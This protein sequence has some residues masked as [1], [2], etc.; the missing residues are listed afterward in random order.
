MRSP[1]SQAS[2][3]SSLVDE[4]VAPPQAPEDCLSATATGRLLAA[5]G[6]V[7]VLLTVAVAVDFGPISRLD[8][9]VAQW[10]YDQTFEKDTL[11]SWWSGVSRWGAPWVLRLALIAAAAL[12]LWRRRMGI[13]VWLV[14]VA[15]V[16]N[17][18][19]PVAK[20][21]LSRPRPEWDNPI[22]VE[23]SLSYPSGQWPEGNE[24]A[25]F[26]SDRVARIRSWAAQTVLGH[27]RNDVLDRCHEHEPYGDA[28][29]ATPQ[30]QSGRSNER[31][32]E[33]PRRAPPGDPA[34]L[35]GQR[36][37]LEGPVVAPLCDSVVES[38]DR[39]EVDGHRD[40]QQDEH[41]AEPREQ[42]TGR[43]GAEAVCGRLRWSHALIDQ[44]G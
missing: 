5:L 24:K 17:V 31:Q 30:L 16:E 44:G 33:N 43:C 11:V 12:Q 14:L 4:R 26:D 18:V 29:A 25:V 13:A 9:A 34:T 20:Y 35:R 6:A 28:H 27:R 39:A 36:V 21:G 2:A 7:F 1:R 32:T 8:H 19:A 3:S 23:H 22:A 15:A 10:G 40:R 37:L 41:G 38:A 42:A